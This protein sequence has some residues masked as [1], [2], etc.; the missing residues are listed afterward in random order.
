[1]VASKD[2]ELDLPG[3]DDLYDVGVAGVVARMLKVP[4][5]TLRILVQGTQRVR[6]KEFVATEPYLVAKIEEEPGRRRAVARA[7][8]AQAQRAGDVLADHRAR[9]RTCPRSSRS[10]SRTWTT[11]P[12]SRYM[13]AGALR[14]LDRGEAGAAR[15]ARR[16]QAAAAAVRA[17][18]ARARADLDRHRGSSRRSSRRWRRAS[19]STSCA[20]SSRRSRRSSAR[21]TS[22]RPR[23]TSCASRWSRRTCPRRSASRS[24]A[25]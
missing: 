4:D 9:S 18:R 15:G 19:A 12:S 1:M 13:I 24:T 5:G 10:R 21:S 7:R 23:S 2:P 22:S 17:A 11:P 8:G 3:P 20:S 25:S 16:R 6:L 14:H